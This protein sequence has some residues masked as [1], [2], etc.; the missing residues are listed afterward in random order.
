MYVLAG[1]ELGSSVPD[2]HRASVKVAKGSDQN[3]CFI[4]CD[5]KS[6]ESETILSPLSLIWTCRVLTIYAMTNLKTFPTFSL[7]DIFMRNM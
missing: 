5:Q 1:F 2:D 3:L 4:F 7:L 6:W